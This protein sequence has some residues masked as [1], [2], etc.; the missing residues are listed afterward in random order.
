M[1]LSDMFFYSFNALRQRSLRS[2][3]T[4]LGIV[5]GITSIILL[6][7]L[8]QGLRDYFTAQ[9]S[10][11]GSRTVVVMP[12][13]IEGGAGGSSFMPSSGKLFMKDYERLKR[14]PEVEEITAVISGRATIG[15]KDKEVTTSVMGIQADTFYQTV[16]SLVLAKGRFLQPADQ[17]SVV[18][19]ATMANDTFGGE[20]PLSSTLRISGQDFRV[21][22]ILNKS[23]S[24]FSPSDSA[25]F[26]PFS[27]AQAMFEGIL[28]DKEISL[29]RLKVQDG[30]NMTE[31]AERITDE[32][33]AAHRVNADSKDFSVITSD[34]INKQLDTVTGMLGLFL[35]GVAG[36][37]LIVGGV[38]IAN[39]MFM[40]VTERRREIGILKSLGAK[41]TEIER[42]FLVESS[43]IGMGGGAIGILLAYL[44]AFTITLLSG[45][46]VHIEPLVVMGAVGFS[47]T[48][49]IIS[50]V[51]PARQAALLDPVE[52]LSG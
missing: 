21:V 23:G 47:A 35:G 14:I 5:V 28:S 44:F 32:M 34:F 16:G 2:W 31:A 4:V 50:G 48:V 15:F 29:I 37:S 33:L 39:T 52:A 6:I 1:K 9:I 27:M 17:G 11:F 42:L 18:I 46:G 12:V 43:L 24:S 51:F 40:S 25:V 30:A 3:L 20:I 45:V 19:G 49:G 7:G 22:G 26:I 10:T 13:N 38:G 41:E 8:V 36:V